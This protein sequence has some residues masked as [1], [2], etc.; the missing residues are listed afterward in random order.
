MSKLEQYLCA[1]SRRIFRLFPIDRR[2]VVFCSYYGKGY[3]DNP[4]AVAEALLASKQ[5]LTLVW[6]LQDRRDAAS[7]PAG[8]RPASYW[9]ISRAWESG[10]PGFRW[11]GAPLPAFPSPWP[12]ATKRYAK[13]YVSWISKNMQKS[14]LILPGK[15]SSVKTAMPLPA[16]PIGFSPDWAERRKRHEARHYLRNL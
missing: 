12:A 7:L 9:G 16:V 2:K 15:I 8:I 10:F 6:L 5:D 13:L 3:S 4:K 11:R 1:I 14:G